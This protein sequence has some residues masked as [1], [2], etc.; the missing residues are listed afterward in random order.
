MAAGLRA[1]ESMDRF[2]MGKKLDKERGFEHPRTADVNLDEI[3]IC[4]FER[5]KIPIIRSQKRLK[6]YEETTLGIPASD[7]LTETQRCLNC[8]SCSQ[9]LEC[10]AACKLGAVRHDETLQNIDIN[11]DAVL[12]FDKDET[13][14]GLMEGVYSFTDVGD[15][16]LS[17]ARAIALE[18]ATG[19]NRDKAETIE[20]GKDEK[21]AVFAKQPA[22]SPADNLRTGVFLCNCGGSI[23]SVIDFK[24]IS[25]K[26]STLPEVAYIY[27]INQSCTE[28]GAREIAGQVEKYGLDRIVLAACRCCNL[29][30]VCYSCTDRR[31]MCQHHLFE[32]LVVPHG[33]VIEYCNIREQC[34]WI[35]NNDHRGATNKALQIVT[36]GVAG[37]GE[38]NYPPVGIKSVVPRVVILGGGTVT[39]SAARA[40]AARGYEVEMVSS[41]EAPDRI[42]ESETAMPEVF[43]K[44]NKKNLVVRRWPESIE[45]TGSPGNYEVSLNNGNKSE[46]INCGVILIDSD[47]LNRQISSAVD[48]KKPNG[49]LGRILSRQKYAVPVS[50]DKD[51]L[52]L[53]V[54]IG[55]R[56]GIFIISSDSHAGSSEEEVLSGLSAA[57]RISTFIEQKQ[58]SARSNAVNIDTEKC[59]GCGDCTNICS[60]IELRSNQDNTTAYIDG[61]LCLGCGAC[62][63]VCPTGAISQSGHSDKQIL[64]AIS[65]ILQTSH[66]HSEV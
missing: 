3:E 8:A 11:V 4:P 21:P 28:T 45:V 34:A 42:P 65:S 33:T 37:I 40:L 27:E 10:I 16:E 62:V 60:Y 2:L 53:E 61:S 12:R 59:R 26:L 55:N 64:A 22:E 24:A 43:T 63:A 18:V 56:S 66:L 49:L 1:A 23:S 6:T 13:D 51:T 57:A 44:Y 17:K 31:Q 39:S 32:Q 52:L 5:V 14:N 58:L 30:Q 50:G 48:D 19:L 41:R 36:A 15:I 54:T 29:E 9:C 35:H 46:N 38:V 20:T 7:A 25:R 47:E